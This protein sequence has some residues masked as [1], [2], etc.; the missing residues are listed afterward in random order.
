MDDFDD[1]ICWGAADPSRPANAWT[2]YNPFPGIRQISCYT[3]LSGFRLPGPPSCCLQTETATQMET[4]VDENGQQIASKKK[5]L[6]SMILK[7]N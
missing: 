6:A 3:L 1:G 2:E 5:M 7:E 4:L